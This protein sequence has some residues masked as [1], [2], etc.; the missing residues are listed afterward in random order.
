[1]GSITQKPLPKT[2]A[3]SQYIDGFVLSIPKNKLAAYKK[4]ATKAAKIWREHGALE[5]RE[6]VGDDMKAKGMLAFP[7][8]A[9]SKPGEVVIFA[10]IVFRSRKQRDATNRKIMADPRI[11]AMCGEGGVVIDCKRMAYGGFQS[12]VEA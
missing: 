6:C 3:M 7:K 9:R 2:H 1:L 4:L 10:Y 11:A 8:L 5:Y 12:L